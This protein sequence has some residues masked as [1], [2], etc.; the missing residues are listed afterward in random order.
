MGRGSS[1]FHSSDRQTLINNILRSSTAE[2]GAELGAHTPLGAYVVAMFPLHMYARLQELRNDWLCIWR[3]RQ[4]IAELDRIGTS[5]IV[6]DGPS[7]IDPLQLQ[8]QQNDGAGDGILRQLGLVADAPPMDGEEAANNDVGGLCCGPVH[9]DDLRT[10]GIPVPH[11]HHAGALSSTAA[12]GQCKF[13]CCICQH[14][15]RHTSPKTGS[16]EG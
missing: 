14:P 16:E 6:A 1:L 9:E 15:C 4:A 12:S 7:L 13:C 10:A 8:A 2:G 3:P 5:L 11:G